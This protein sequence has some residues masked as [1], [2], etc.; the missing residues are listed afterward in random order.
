[1][2][3]MICET[4]STML[5]QWD[6]NAFQNG[7][8][9]VV[10]FSRQLLDQA[11]KESCGKDVFCREGAWQVSEIIADITKG[12]IEG[13]EPDLLREL[14]ALI[15]ENAGCEMSRAA[16][17]RCLALMD[18]YKDEWDLHIRRKRCTNLICK[19][20]YLLYLSPEQC[21]GC[22]KCLEVC[23]V[24]VIAGGKDMIHVINTELCDKCGKCVEVCP[25]GAVKKASAG[26]L[27][28]KAP[29]A[30]VPVGSFGGPDSGEEG[31]PMR[32]RRRGE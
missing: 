24:G 13:E 15:S 4:K 22:G 2:S 6:D 9:C 27:K 31:A 8:S 3:G 7:N 29:A 11:R 30:P 10:E 14:L 25:K 32:R 17:A 21:D 5:C 20:S 23:P 12:R 19:P 18:Q 28:P 16:A 1:M 26:G